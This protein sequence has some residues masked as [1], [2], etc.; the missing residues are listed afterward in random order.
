MFEQENIS[1]MNRPVKSPMASLDEHATLLASPFG[2]FYSIV[3]PLRVAI[4]SL[5]ADS[6]GQ[7]FKK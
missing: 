6:N 4:V 7:P 1:A 2:P 3:L 5:L